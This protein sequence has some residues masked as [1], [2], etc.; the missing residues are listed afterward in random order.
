MLVVCGSATS[1]MTDKLI[2]NHGGLYNRL[3]CEI[4]LAPFSLGE[5]EQYYISENI[6]M[7]RYDIIQ[8]YMITGGIPYYLSY[9]QSGLSLAQNVDELF[10][11]KKAPLLNEFNRFFL[12]FLSK[13]YDY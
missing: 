10:F 8:S 7:S 6:K 9:Y 11:K 3:T 12:Q 5:C 2:N 13:I 1:W 4:K